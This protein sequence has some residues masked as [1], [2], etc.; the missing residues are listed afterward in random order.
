MPIGTSPYRLVFG[1][2]CHLPVELEHKAFWALKALNFELAFAVVTAIVTGSPDFSIL[3]TDVETGTEIVRLENSHE[4]V[5]FEFKAAVN[6]IVN[7]TESTVASA[8]NRAEPRRLYAQNSRFFR[9]RGKLPGIQFLKHFYDLGVG[10]GFS[11]A[12]PFYNEF[13]STSVFPD[14]IRETFSFL[15]SNFFVCID[16]EQ[17]FKLY[18]QL[19]ALL[20][21][22]RRVLPLLMAACGFGASGF[23]LTNLN[24]G[25]SKPKLTALHNLRTKKLSQS[26]GLLLTTKS[27]KTLFGCWCS[28]A[29]VE[30]A[31]AAVSHSSD[32]SSRKIISSETASPLIPSSYEVESL[33]TEICDTTSIA[34]V[35]LK[36]GG[37]H[38]YVKR[39]LTGPSTTSLPAISNPVNIHSSVEVADSNGSASSPS[40][41]I[42]KSS[43][44]SDGIRTIIDKA[45]DEGLVI[46]Q[47]P[48]VGYFRR[49]RTIKGKRAPPSCKEKQQVKEGQVVCFIEQLGGELPV[50]SDVSGEVIK[51]LQ[52]DGD[53]VGYGDPLISILPSFP[54]IKKLQ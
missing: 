18:Q 28:T 6:R 35:D 29:E 40:L 42:T 19:S 23:K 17:S 48:R 11:F 49:S 21:S 14:V 8:N 43:P 34:E 26:D 41:A 47:S 31:A 30:S 9:I 53:P 22:S 38:L 27:R 24:L 25:S 15:L 2:A 5:T 51:I 46:I 20:C 54:G 37:F 13:I 10:P 32:D 44:P 7:L 39:D 50:E 4:K 36:L 3:A 33:L 16:N 12:Q 52:K 45:A 1:K